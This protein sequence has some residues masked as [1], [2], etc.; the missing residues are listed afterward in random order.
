[1]SQDILDQFALRAALRSSLDTSI[2]I[3]GNDA[4]FK[5]LRGRGFIYTNCNKGDPE[6]NHRYSI[7]F[8]S[9][10]Y[11][12][13]YLPRLIN[14]CKKEHHLHRKADF[15]DEKKSHSI[16][17]LKKWHD[18]ESVKIDHTLL[19]GNKTYYSTNILPVNFILN[20]E[21]G[22]HVIIIG[23]D[24]DDRFNLANTFLVQLEYYKYEILASCPDREFADLLNL[25]DRISKEYHSFLYSNRTDEMFDLIKKILEIRS[26]MPE[27]KWKP[28]FILAFMWDKMIGI[29]I[30]DDYKTFDDF[31]EILQKAPSL[32]IH[33]IIVGRIAKVFSSVLPFIN[34]KICTQ[35]DEDTSYKLLDSTK[36]TKLS[37][38]SNISRMA[39]Y[40]KG[41]Q[42]QKFKIY[43]SH[44]DTQKL[45]KESSSLCQ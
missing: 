4:A 27:K 39:I 40:L 44:I 3:L 21:D 41:I 35:C 36:G 38:D 30:G 31:K 12:K 13:E 2:D 8:T 28:I 16:E 23:L 29:G 25:N 45:K 6:E 17:E 18:S 34:H 42:E 11:I 10:Q 20:K 32:N 22:E 26:E 9:N 14:K 1:M 43:Q 33:F 37:Q 7:P 15:Y 19:L 24:R 5:K